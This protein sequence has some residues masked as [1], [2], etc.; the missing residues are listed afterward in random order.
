MADANWIDDFT[1]IM[2]SAS[3]VLRSVSGVLKTDETPGTVTVKTGT[4][5]TPKQAKVELNPA[6]L[7][8][9][10]WLI[11]GGIVLVLVLLSEVG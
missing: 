8:T 1:K 3:G 5:T 4:D 9:P 7:A 6:P 10:P 11:L 2:D